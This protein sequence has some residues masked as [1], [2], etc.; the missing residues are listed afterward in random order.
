MIRLRPS[1]IDL[2]PQDVRQ[3]LD[4]VQQERNAVIARASQQWKFQ[5]GW[6]KVDTSDAIFISPAYQLVVAYGPFGVEEA[7]AN[8]R[9]RGVRENLTGVA[10]NAPDPRVDTGPIN[11]NLIP[12]HG[13]YGPA[14]NR[15]S[16]PVGNDFFHSYLRRIAKK[17]LAWEDLPEFYPALATVHTAGQGISHSSSG[18]RGEQGPSS[19]Q[20]RSEHTVPGHGDQSEDVR[21]WIGEDHDPGHRG[22]Q[23]GSHHWQ[24]VRL[25]HVSRPNNDAASMQRPQMRDDEIRHQ[26]RSAMNGASM[27]RRS[28]PL[29]SRLSIAQ[30]ASSSPRKE[31]THG[32]SHD[33][34]GQIPT[35]G[36]PGSPEQW[37][38]YQLRLQTST[39]SESDTDLSPS[40][41]SGTTEASV[42]H[43]RHPPVTDDQLASDLPLLE[44]GVERLMSVKPLDVS[45]EEVR[46]QRTPPATDEPS[47]PIWSRRNRIDVRDPAITP[48]PVIAIAASASRA[49]PRSIR[50]YNDE[51]PAS[52]QPQTLTNR[53]RRQFN[54]AY[55]APSGLRRVFRLSGLR[56]PSRSGTI[57]SVEHDTV[58]TDAADDEE[59][60]EN[61]SA[62]V[63]AARWEQRLRASLERRHNW[64]NWTRR[65]QSADDVLIESEDAAASGAE[66]DRTPDAELHPLRRQ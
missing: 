35:S 66:M 14:L 57:P 10:L 55:T 9:A 50:V 29:P 60:Q 31:P 3:S 25:S 48:S 30:A 59:D 13:D 17:E 28:R 16:L 11:W 5:D 43:H 41:S 58:I 20:R 22:F 54:P 37:R 52:E 7:A 21:T 61:A 62:S 18:P 45:S 56:R 42:V 27:Y 47:T 33:D 1:Q 63:E 12:D 39:A 36:T 64:R 46:G 26:S 23:G 15:L 4:R 19:I 6:Q 49:A 51:L 65:R 53:Y 2:S 8:R 40:M 32:R 44:S 34:D 38:E 24:R